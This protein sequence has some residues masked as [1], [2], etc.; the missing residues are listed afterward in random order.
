MLKGASFVIWH[1]DDNYILMF[2]YLY[3]LKVSYRMY[4]DSSSLSFQMYVDRKKY[5]CKPSRHTT[6]CIHVKIL[7]QRWFHVCQ[8]HNIQSALIQYSFNMVCS[9]RNCIHVLTMRH[10]FGSVSCSKHFNCKCVL[11]TELYLQ[12]FGIHIYI[13]KYR[14]SLCKILDWS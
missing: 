3:F 5:H 8:R 4:I 1:L 10:I 13:Y 2:A 11:S 9:L 7:N 6:L 14:I 12:F